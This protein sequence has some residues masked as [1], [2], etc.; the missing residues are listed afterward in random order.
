MQNEIPCKGGARNLREQSSDY[1]IQ[2]DSYL[3]LRANNSI[4]VMMAMV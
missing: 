1:F 2:H 4:S 3:L